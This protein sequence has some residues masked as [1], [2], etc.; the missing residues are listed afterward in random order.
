MRLRE[1]SQ[2]ISLFAPETRNP[3]DAQTVIDAQKCASRS[4][5]N[6]LSILLL[7]NRVVHYTADRVSAA[8]VR[9]CRYNSVVM[10][11]DGIRRERRSVRT[12]G[13]FSIPG[14]ESF[15]S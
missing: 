5:P 4:C 1:E 10:L 15:F 8:T 7:D 2:S 14:D 12:V 6:R 13:A 3:D 11:Q 9:G